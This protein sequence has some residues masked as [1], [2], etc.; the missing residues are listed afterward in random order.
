MCWPQVCLCSVLARLC[1]TRQECWW[2]RD[3]RGNVFSGSHR[4][5]ALVFIWQMLSYSKHLTICIYYRDNRAKA[6]VRH[7]LRVKVGMKSKFTVYFYLYIVVLLNAFRMEISVHSL[8]FVQSFSI[9]VASSN[10][11]LPKNKT[12][13]RPIFFFRH[14]RIILI[15]SMSWYGKKDNF[16]FH[17]MPTFKVELIVQRIQ[18]PIFEPI[19]FR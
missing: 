2:W 10:D 14:F 13:H 6:T 12:M 17:Y 9:L 15:G 18:F 5:G 16:D 11:W 1:H 7:L 19:S 3:Y 8:T 4:H